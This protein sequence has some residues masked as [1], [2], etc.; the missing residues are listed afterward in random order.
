METCVYFK[1]HFWDF[2][3]RSNCVWTL[4]KKVLRPSSGRKNLFHVDAELVGEKQMSRLYG[5]FGQ[6]AMWAGKG[7]ASTGPIR[8]TFKNGPFKGQRWGMC[9]WTDV[10]SGLVEKP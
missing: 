9:E 3:Q 10:S 4:R 2:T 7:K 1:V 5:E 8:D 6:W